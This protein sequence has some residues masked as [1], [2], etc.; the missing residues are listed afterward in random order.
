MFCPAI[1]SRCCQEAKLETT[2]STHSQCVPSVALFQWPRRH[3]SS[4]A[5]RLCSHGHGG[6]WSPWSVRT[7]WDWLTLFD[8]FFFWFSSHNFN[9]AKLWNPFLAIIKYFSRLTFSKY[10]STNCF[11]PLSLL[12]TRT[13]K[14][15][16]Q[17]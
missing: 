17:P 1:L 3:G 4:W 13:L 16:T 9:T 15:K 7:L 11:R 14:G 2:S 10:C 8:K 5:Q 6:V 12:C